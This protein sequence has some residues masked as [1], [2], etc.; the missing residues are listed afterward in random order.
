M[1]MITVESTRTLQLLS[2]AAEWKLL[3]LLLSCPQG[4]WRPQVA[5]L[6]EETSNVPL[7]QAAQLMAEQA[8]EGL[9]HTTF[10]PGGPAAPREVSHREYMIPGASLAELAAYYE[11]F[12]VCP[13]TDEPP[14]HVA[15]ECDFLAYLRVKE[16]YALARDNQEQATVAA[17]AARSFARDHLANIAQPLFSSLMDSGIEYLRLA[18]QE[19][20]HRVG[21]IP[22]AGTSPG[23][24]LPVLT[25]ASPDCRGLDDDDLSPDSPSGPFF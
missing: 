20:L 21:T 22:N 5:L 18:A 2:E 10:G 16:S 6:A 23:I 4:D 7:Q 11:A 3:A 14:D 25:A 8:S 12:A 13:A 19:L 17:E 15:V 1:K 9:Y 24:P